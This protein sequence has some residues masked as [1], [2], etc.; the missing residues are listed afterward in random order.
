MT[1]LCQVSV[2]DGACR[3]P[4]PCGCL[5][6][7]AFNLLESRHADEHG[8]AVGVQREVYAAN[9]SENGRSGGWYLSA[10]ALPREVD[11]GSV[12]FN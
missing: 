10:R 4:M 1:A 3:Q 8:A 11:P 6:A 7:W 2:P 12:D 9:R 5:L